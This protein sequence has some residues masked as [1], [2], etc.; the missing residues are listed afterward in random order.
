[1]S[2]V[3]CRKTISKPSLSLVTLLDILKL[4]HNYSATS[5]HTHRP[6]RLDMP[7]HNAPIVIGE[8]ADPHVSNNGDRESPYRLQEVNQVMG[9]G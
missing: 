2:S 8:S 1:M 6:V 5:V 4:N 7:I 3:T 9:V